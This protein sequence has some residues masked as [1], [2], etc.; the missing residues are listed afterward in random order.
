[1]MPNSDRDGSE[2][3]QRDAPY[4]DGGEWVGSRCHECTYY[5]WVDKQAAA[6]SGPNFC[7][8]CGNQLATDDVL[9]IADRTPDQLREA[10]Q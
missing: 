3:P 7:A 10:T 2:T 8:A 4:K 1:M 6:A 9:E 5:T